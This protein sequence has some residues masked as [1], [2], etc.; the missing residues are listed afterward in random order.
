MIDRNAP[1]LIS[2][3]IVEQDEITITIR[4]V[5]DLRAPGCP[6]IAI[7]TSNFTIDTDVTE[8]GREFS[9]SRVEHRHL[10]KAA[11]ESRAREIE[12]AIQRFRDCGVEMERFSIQDQPNGM[13][14]LCVDGVRRFTWFIR[15]PDQPGKGT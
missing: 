10:L 11:M 13:T 8:F 15:W 9:L 12:A 1:G 4:E 2:R 7:R 5:W 6:Y 3:E 14:H